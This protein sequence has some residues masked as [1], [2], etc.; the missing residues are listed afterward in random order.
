[1]RQGGAVIRAR[2]LGFRLDGG[3]LIAV[4]ADRDQLAADVAVVAAGAW[5]KPLAA[6]LGDKVPLET[7]RGYHL[8][9]RDPEVMPKIPT[10]D[11]DGK[12]VA[13]PMDTGRRCAGTVELP[14]LDGPREWRRA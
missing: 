8:M 13:T 3:Q 11:G 7:E 10:A 1:M 12:F 6:S 9:I 2:A 14:R 5:S 4:G